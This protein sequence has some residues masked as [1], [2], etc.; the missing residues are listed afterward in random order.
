MTESAKALPADWT[1]WPSRLQL[2]PANPSHAQVWW[3]WRQEAATQRHNPL[4]D[5]DPTEL[6]SRLSLVGGDLRDKSFAEYRWMVLLDAKAVGTISLSRP[7]WRMGFGE[8]GY[9]LSE[10][11]QGK[12]LGTAAVGVFVD[13]LF[14]E[15]NLVRLMAMISTENVPSWRLV[16]RLGFV[17]EGMLRQHYVIQGQRVDEYVYGLLR[18][19]WLGSPQRQALR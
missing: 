8:I 2:V 14:R 13:K 11:V 15:T 18:S 17:R 5:I 6:A 16:E 19:E 7:S 1:A 9:M 4:D 12:G 3:R 10:S